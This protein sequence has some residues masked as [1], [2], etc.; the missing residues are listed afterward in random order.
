MSTVKENE[1]EDAKSKPNQKN[2]LR[3]S[4]A[5]KKNEELVKNLNEMS[6]KLMHAIRSGDTASTEV[7]IR[8]NVNLYKEVAEKVRMLHVTLRSAMDING[9]GKLDAKDFSCCIGCA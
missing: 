3:I 7:Y 8:E 1:H 9:D 4:D 6:A 5:I 2:K